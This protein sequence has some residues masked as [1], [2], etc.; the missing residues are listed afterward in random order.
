MELKATR[1]EQAAGV[2]T[3]W[4][5]RPARMNAWTGRMHTEYRWCLAQLDADA[6]V[7]VIVVTGAERGFCV[8]GDAQALV[9]HAQKGRYDPGVP[10]QLARPGFG[11]APEFD[12]VFACH[13]GLRKPIIAA[14]NGPAA[15]VG[16]ALACF[17]DLRFA[18]PERVR[19]Y[20]ALAEEIQRTTRTRT[21]AEW[22]AALQGAGVPA[23]PIYGTDEAL[24]DAHV[25]ARDMVVEL[26]HPAA[27]R[28][29]NLG[30]PV[31]LSATPG[32]VRTP[33]PTLGE[34]TESVLR[35]FGV[36]GEQAAAILA[37]G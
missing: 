30:V 9:G 11:V 34:H 6:A 19:N 33:A 12:A 1:M 24:A 26:D 15:G 5:H 29:N 27:G 4:L 7:G 14:I 3:I 21:S 23:G 36:P 17:A 20:A 18:V 32:R 16:L 35:A 22:L 8:G 13:F 31:K 2:G 28:V 25:R 37:R 10:A